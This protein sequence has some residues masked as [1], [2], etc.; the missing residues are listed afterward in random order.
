MPDYPINPNTRFRSANAT[1]GQTVF[2]V[3]FPLFDP[4]EVKVVRIRAGISTTLVLT[5][6]Y[7]LS[8]LNVE[9]GFICTLTAASLTG[10]VVEFWGATELKRTGDYGAGQA[11]PSAAINADLDRAVMRDQEL[12]RDIDN[13]QIGGD[14][15][16]ARD[17]AVAAAAAASASQT[18]AA[19]SAG[20]AST[21]ATN[22]GN[23]AAA[24]ATSAGSASTSATNAGNSA[25]AAAGSAGTASTG[26]TN[27]G[28]SATAAATSATNA[29]NSATAAAT[30]ATNAGNSATAAATSA[31][32]AATSLADVLASAKIVRTG[33]GAPAGGLG[34]NGDVYIDTAA[35]FVYR[36]AA[37]AWDG[38]TK[39]IGTDG[40]G[41]G[42]MLGPASSTANNIVTFLNGTGKS[43]KDSGVPISSLAPLN[44]PTLTGNPTA[45]T[46]SLG[47]N[48]TSIATTG[49]VKAAID[50]VLGGV[51]SA[52]DTLSEIVAS[53]AT[54]TGAETLTN[55]T[56]TAPVI[57]GTI[58]EDIFTITDAAAFEIDPAN[59]SIQQ[60]TLGASRTPKGTNF[61]AGH[62]LTLHI[63]DGTAFALTWTD[64]T[65]GAAGINWVGGS[66][67]ALATTGWTVVVLWKMGGQVFGKYIGDVAA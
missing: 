21:G 41:A 51:S 18:A 59:G 25:T 63:N 49:F 35:W 19:A 32:N 34:N 58:K 66:A 67:P 44:S 12:R 61:Q 5:T 23:S 8:N 64:T 10:D 42:D 7:T 27:A 6:H 45:P 55:K 16:E 54:K 39:M 24:A 46:P 43:A 28:N 22:A 20:T 56:L 52:F 2:N 17:Q 14:I 65:F 48:D 11:L 36:K 47:D 53:M 13:L 29:A 1:A 15:I 62:S 9:A 57:D 30:S 3:A 31:T 38:G 37:G 60:V 50:V 33:S 26:A 40:V 4:A